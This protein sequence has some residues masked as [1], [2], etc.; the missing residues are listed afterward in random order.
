MK[1]AHSNGGFDDGFDDG[2]REATAFD[3]GPNWFQK[4]TGQRS[5]A[6]LLLTNGH[7]GVIQSG[8]SEGLRTMCR[9]APESAVC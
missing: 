2:Y 8:N 6:Q 7:I 4:L 9:R 3:Q 5:A 1:S